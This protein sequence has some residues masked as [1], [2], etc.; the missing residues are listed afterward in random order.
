MSGKKG[1]PAIFLD[2]DGTLNESVGYVNHKSRF[3][4]FPW[5]VEAPVTETLAETTV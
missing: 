1:K 4:L 3:R 5:S 2:R